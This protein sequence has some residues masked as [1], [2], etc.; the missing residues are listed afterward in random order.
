MNY[1]QSLAYLDLLAEAGI[2]AGLDHTRALARELGDPQRAFPSV[3][4]AGTNGK[5][6]VCATLASIL[7]VS[8]LRVGLY[9]SPHLVDVRERALVDGRK[10]GRESFA[11]LLTEVRRRAEEAA[12]GGVVEGMPTHFEALTLLAFLHFARSAVDLAV[13]EVG[14][15]GRL[16]CTNIVEPSLSLI[17]SVARDHEEWLGRGLRNI[18]RE[19]AGILRPGV[20]ALTSATR[21]EVLEVLMRRA[22]EM[23]A[24]LGTPGEVRV[25]RG[26]G[27]WSLS[28]PEGSLGELPLP[29]LPGEHQ[30][31]NAALACRAALALR[32]K[33]WRISDRAVKEG[34]RATRWPGRL[35]KVRENPG[36][37]LDGAHNIEGCEALRRF[38]EGLPRPR[39]LVFAAMRDKPLEEMG[40]VLFSAFD[41]V[42]AT[43]VPMDRCAPA[44]GIPIGHGPGRFV[45]PIF[46]RAV[47][48]ASDLAGPGGSVVVAGSLYFVGRLM[49]A[50]GIPGGGR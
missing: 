37:Y 23:G 35:Q 30:V 13:V 26:E 12:D 43:Q 27:S 3:L 48:R 28:C 42:V 9:T 31:E 5:G 39:V 2:K 45:E 14:L 46:E 4:V 21:P 44:E 40:S 41:A 49:A 24:R 22:R 18:A 29:S 20:P 33:G 1:P 7:R 38:A 25:E 16:D 32:S 10:M 6:S 8:S 19:K 15:G 17:T 11:A 34:L 47:Q 36:T 50:W